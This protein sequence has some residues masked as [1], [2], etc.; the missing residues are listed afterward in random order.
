MG[1]NLDVRISNVFEFLAELDNEKHKPGIVSPPSLDPLH[2][3][4]DM[5]IKG[6]RM[7]TVSISTKERIASHPSP[8]QQ[9]DFRRSSVIII[10]FLIHCLVLNQL[11]ILKEKFLCFFFLA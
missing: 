5:S 10:P 9:N 8:L 1:V 6:P 4:G 7:P 11:A 3:T 2:V